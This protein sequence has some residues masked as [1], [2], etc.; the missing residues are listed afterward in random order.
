MTSEGCGS[1]G[2]TKMS[3]VP[4]LGHMLL[5]KRMPSAALAGLDAEFRVAGPAAAPTPIRGCAIGERLAR[6]LQHRTARTTAADPAFATSGAFRC[7]D[8]LR[9]GLRGRH[10]DRPHYGREH[11]GAFGRLHL[12]RQR[13]RGARRQR[14]DRDG[15]R[16]RRLHADARGVARDPARQPRAARAA[17]PTASSSR[18]RTTRR[19]TA[20]SSTTRPTAAPPTPTPPS[21]SPTRPTPTSRPA[22]P[23]CGAPP[24]RGRGPARRRTTSWDLRRRPAQRRRPGARQGG[25]HPD[26]RRPARRRVGGLLGRDRRPARPR[27]DRGQP[28]GGPDLALHDARLGREDPDGLLARRPRWRR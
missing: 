1:T 27:P 22:S 10:R 11:E 20:A 19:A 3:I 23:A 12:R 6:R 28:A 24:S 18:P 2:S 15:R 26:R 14:R 9:A 25:R 4:L 7:D 13:A 8:R 5:A 16:P 21:G 17:W